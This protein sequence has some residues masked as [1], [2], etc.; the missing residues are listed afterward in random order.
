MIYNRAIRC[1]PHD[2]GFSSESDFFLMLP[3]LTLACS[4]GINIQISVKLLSDKETEFKSDR[5]KR[6]KEM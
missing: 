2:D 1:H 4:L 3:L 6:E 5:W